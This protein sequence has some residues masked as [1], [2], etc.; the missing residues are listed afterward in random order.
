MRKITCLLCLICIISYSIFLPANAYEIHYISSEEELFNIEK[1]PTATFCLTCDIVIEN[2][3]DVL[4]KNKDNA[5][6]GTLDGN[7]HTIYSLNL[8]NDEEILAFIGFLGQDG[9][10]KNLNF[11]E[12]YYESGNKNASVGGIVALNYGIITNCSFSGYILQYKKPL[13]KYKYICTYDLGKISNSKYEIIKPEHLKDTSSVTSKNDVIL[14][15][16][17]VS[18]TSIK[19][20]SS[21]NTT[22]KEITE[23]KDKNSVSVSSK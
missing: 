1:Y 2:K 6:N 17:V 22:S 11:Q 8:S 21:E 20:T 7:G 12:A 23:S 4:F 19:N 14:S 16:S 18:N 10:I 15:E 13:E 3:N 9:V 5:F